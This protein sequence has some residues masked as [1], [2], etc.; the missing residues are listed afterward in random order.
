MAA[1][2]KRVLVVDDDPDVVDTIK[3]VLESG[4]Y[5]VI[6]AANGTEG[7]AKA[8]SAAPALVVLDVM[9]DMETEGFH[10]AYD[11]REGEKTKGIK[12]LVLTNVAKKSG[13]KFAPET[14]EEY[15]PVDAFMEKPV[16]PKVLLAK[17]AELVGK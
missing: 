12:I 5:E 7:L 16:E 1:P 9:M 6:T 3:A 10:V 13:F 2:K 17:V 8:K 4:G 15:L 11:L 14:D